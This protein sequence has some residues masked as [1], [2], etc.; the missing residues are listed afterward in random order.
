MQNRFLRISFLLQ[1]L[2]VLG[3]ANAADIMTVEDI[4]LLERSLPG[5]VIPYGDDPS[6]FGELSLP[7]GAGPHPVIV[8][9]HGGC[10][11]SQYGIKHSRIVAQAFAQNGFAVWNLEYRRVGNP[12]GGWPG[13]FL[14]IGHGAD[15]LRSLAERFP[16]DLSRIIVGGHS[17][18]GHLALWLAA[19]AK[20]A[21]DS[22]IYIG[23]PLPVHGVLALAPAA[24]LE[25]LYEKAACDSVVEKL[26]GGAP[27]AVPERYAAASPI[28]MAPL[29]LP[30][31]IVIGDHDEHWTWVGRAY[32]E[33]ARAAGDH[34]IRMIE[35][36][37]SGHF[38]MVYPPSS[39]WPLVLEALHSLAE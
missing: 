24:Q 10:W 34:N 38:E 13:T 20:I 15:H 27:E 8:W 5:I 22:D 12:G 33:A 6:Q 29:G 37:D 4:P 21:A 2:A 3:V 11:L 32:A 25:A 7:K 16:L 17:A 39:T 14:D 28:H 1:L 31:A 19:R 30:Q 26:I 35:A 18:G 36:P 23:N 9:I